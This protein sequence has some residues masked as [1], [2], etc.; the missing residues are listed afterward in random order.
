MMQNCDELFKDILDPKYFRR[1]QC[2]IVH[3]DHSD[4]DETIK[5]VL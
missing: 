5:S 3:S 4:E 2:T 1:L